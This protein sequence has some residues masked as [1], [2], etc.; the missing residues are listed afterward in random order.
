MDQA[1]TLSATPA[2]LEKPRAVKVALWLAF[3]VF[4]AGAA[5]LYAVRG[6]AILFDLS[7]GIAGM[8]CM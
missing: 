1:D 4:L 6:V 7:S 8:L 3:A 2:T 5:Y